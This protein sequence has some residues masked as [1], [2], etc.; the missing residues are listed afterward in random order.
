MIIY[1][2]P[3]GELVTRNDPEGRK[4]VF[5]HL[6]RLPTGAGSRS[7]AWMNS[8]GLLLLTND[9]ELANRLMHPRTQID[10]EYAVRV[11]GEV[12]PEMVRQLVSGV[13]LEDGPARFEDVV[14]AGER[15][16]TA[17]F[18]WS[19]WK[20]ANARCVAS[21]RRSGHGVAPQARALWTDHP[22]QQRQGGQWRELDGDEQRACLKVVEDQ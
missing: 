8:A 17:G 9:G 2:K 20:V 7:V 10:R 1:N 12:T 16:A 11:N 14:D 6:P 21:G 19:S 13:Q 22:R 3:E 4:T 18:T 5:E 15:A